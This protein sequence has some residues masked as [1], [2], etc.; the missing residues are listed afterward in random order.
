[1]IERDVS[2]REIDT[3]SLPLQTKALGKLRYPQDGKRT[4]KESHQTNISSR[5]SPLGDFADIPES[6]C[7]LDASDYFKRA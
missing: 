1:M 5:R 4:Y 7:T 6:L 2:L 3:N